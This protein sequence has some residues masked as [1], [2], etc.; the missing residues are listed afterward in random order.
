[1]LM[2]KT[3]GN[4]NNSGDIN[5]TRVETLTVDRKKLVHHAKTYSD[6]SK[7]IKKTKVGLTDA[8]RK[9]AKFRY[10]AKM[11]KLNEDSKNQKKVDAKII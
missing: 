3:N 1:M 5:R 10:T 6:T 4:S 9:E 7:I 11:N 2:P 8:Q